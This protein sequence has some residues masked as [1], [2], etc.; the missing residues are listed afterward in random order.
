MAI[1]LSYL[2]LLLSF[3]AFMTALSVSARIDKLEPEFKKNLA[4]QPAASPTLSDR[5]NSHTLSS[6]SANPRERSC[7]A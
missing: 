4:D 5:P 7:R 2:A 3:G 1:Y 6:I